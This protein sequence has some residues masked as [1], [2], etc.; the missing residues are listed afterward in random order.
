MWLGY[1]DDKKTMQYKKTHIIDA[2]RKIPLKQGTKLRRC[3]RCCE[4]IED[5]A[6]SRNMGMWL[7]NVNRTCLCGS[8]WMHG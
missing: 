5:L 6:P 4:V 7:Q 8:M 2:I 3:I 1:H